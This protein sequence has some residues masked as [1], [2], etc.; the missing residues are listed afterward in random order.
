M[1]VLGVDPGLTRCGFG[2]VEGT[3][4]RRPQLR[5]VGVVRTPAADDLGARLVALDLAAAG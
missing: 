3:P 4:G 2:A 1:L 5:E